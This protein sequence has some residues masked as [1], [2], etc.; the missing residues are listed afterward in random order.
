MGKKTRVKRRDNLN[1]AASLAKST[2]GALE[3]VACSAKVTHYLS[4]PVVQAALLFLAVLAAYGHTL[5]FPFIFDDS[6]SIRA[7]PAIYYL[8]DPASIWR[9]APLRFVGYLTFALNYHWHRYDVFGYHA[10]NILIHFMAGIAV[11]SLCRGLVRSPGV[12]GKI[13]KS[14][15]QWL[16]FLAALIFLLHPLQTQAVTY[17]VQRLAALAAL[18]YLGAMACYINARLSRI[19]SQRFYWGAGTVALALLAFF[20]KQNTVTLPIAIL[21]LEMIFFPGN[22][23]KKLLRGIAISALALAALYAVIVVGFNQTPFSLA[24]LESLTKETKTISRTQYLATQAE[25]IWTYIR[26]F[27]WPAGLHLDYDFPLAEGFGSVAVIIAAAG[28]LILLGLALRYVK[29]FPFPVFALFFY[30]T[31]HLVESSLIPIRD[32]LFEHRT[33]LSNAGFCV[34]AAWGITRLA[35]NRKSW[36]ILITFLLVAGLGTLTWTRNLTWQSARSVWLDRSEE[37]TSELQSR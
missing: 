5:N 36:L 15:V 26:L 18:F 31:A 16:P 6:S 32:V 35:V 12:S 2:S 29:R 7:N 19:R 17:I 22:I 28:H 37:H 20:T 9:F 33:Y 14:G 27:F 30:Y 10:F 1:Q 25:V 34:G 13:S 11:F 24:T 8:E 4:F 23:N 21:F 3:G